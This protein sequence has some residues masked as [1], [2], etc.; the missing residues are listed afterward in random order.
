MNWT[1]AVSEIAPTPSNSAFLVV[2]ET[3]VNALECTQS[4]PQCTAKMSVQLMYTQRLEITDN[5]LR[6]LRGE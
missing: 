4:I 2:Y 1:G 3:T 6:E 5:A